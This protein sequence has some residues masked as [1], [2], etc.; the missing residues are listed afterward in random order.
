[1][2][3]NKT[4]STYPW[5]LLLIG[6]AFGVL[7]TLWATRGSVQTVT[8]YREAGAP[9]QIWLQATQMVEQATQM[10]ADMQQSAM[11]NHATANAYTGQMQP[12]AADPFFMTATAVVMQATAAAEQVHR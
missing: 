1:M 3:R 10:A 8:V 12:G 4:W 9:D 7:V 11:S 2:Q 6:F 5:W